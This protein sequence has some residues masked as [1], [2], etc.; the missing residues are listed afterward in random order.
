MSNVYPR[1]TDEFV[2]VAVSV[3]RAPVTSGVAIAIVPD[4]Q[5]PVS[6]TP[7]LIK[8]GN[9][10]FRLRNLAAGIW[11]VYARVVLVDETP[12]IDCGRFEVR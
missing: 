4:G 6:Y 7:A 3:N 10:G 8:E 1:E 5:R 2:R 11:H 9:T 12:V